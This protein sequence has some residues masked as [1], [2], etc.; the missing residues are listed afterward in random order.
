MIKKI[1]LVLLI[2]NIKSTFAQPPANYYNNAANKSCATLKTALKTII[3]QG[4]NL[5]AYGDLWTQYTISDIKTRTVGS[6]SANVI[7]DIYS[8]RPGN[9]DPYQFTPVTN[10]CGS[11]NGEGVCYN[12]EHS[13]PQS[14]FNGNTS[15]PG[16]ATDYIHIF[17]TDG[18]VNGKRDNNIYGEVANANWTSLN[19]SKLGTSAIAGFTGSVFEPIDSFKGDVARAFLYF[20]TRY[21]ND[22]VS[23]AGNADAAQSFDANTFPSVKINYLK[24]MIKWHKLDPVSTK[25]RN[26]NNAAYTFQGNRN[27]FVDRPEFVDSVWNANCPGLSLLPVDIIA[28][29]GKV[30]NNNLVLNWEVGTENNIKLYE[31]ERS[32]NAVTF[33]KI[34][35]QVANRS[36]S[37]TYSQNIDEIRGRRVYYRIK[38]VDNDGKYSYSDVFTIHTQLNTKFSVYPNPIKDNLTLQ[39]SSNSNKKL[40]LTI[41]DLAGRTL[42][43]TNVTSNNGFINANVNSLTNGVYFVNLNVEDEILTA[44]IVVEK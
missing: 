21:E 39:L 13:I 41:T 8:S 22:M 18:A 38:K 35:E 1:T 43:Q 37:Y 2:L 3:S 31:I 23:F 24:L 32:F 42:L 15:S 11:Y 7:N 9:T 19:G 36:S 5:Q 27:P 16:P 17:P 30:N 4:N 10:Q 33:N 20:V 6:G 40:Q 34:G 28:F 29:T 25:E 14:W 26:R 44:K 12:R